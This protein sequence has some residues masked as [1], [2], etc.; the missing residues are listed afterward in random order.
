MTLKGEYVPLDIQTNEVGWQRFTTPDI[1]IAD[2]LDR[3][4]SS[5]FEWIIK[6]STGD[7]SGIDCRFRLRRV[8]WVR[9]DNL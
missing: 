5:T 3:T 8:S 4:G 7:G 9:V 1:T 6:A 2:G